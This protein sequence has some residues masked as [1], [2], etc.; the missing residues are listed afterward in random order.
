MPASKT[1]GEA[2]AGLSVAITTPFK[3]GEVDYER[4]AQQIEFQMQAGTKCLCPVGT[5]GE[6]PTLSHEE[7]ER[8]IAVVGRN[9]RRPHQGHARHRLEQHGG[10]PAADEM[11]GRR[12][13]R[14]RV[15][16]RAVL[17]QAHA[18]R[19]LP[20]LQGAGRSGRHSDLRLQHSRPHR[21]EHRARKRSSAW[22]SCRTSPWSRKPPARSTRPRRF[23]ARRTSPCSAAT[24]A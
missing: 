9:G 6:S 1:R 19:L 14:C 21:Q 5:T 3:D 7:H 2:F 17:Q 23:S 10:S 24:T 22:P 20:T 18:R 15:G 8:V 13:G 12:R 4:F 16:G 11:G